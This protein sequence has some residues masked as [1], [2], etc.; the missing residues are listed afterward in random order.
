MDRWGMIIG[1]RD[2]DRSYTRRMRWQ[3]SGS[4]IL[5]SKRESREGRPGL[6]FENIGAPDQVPAGAFDAFQA[7][8]E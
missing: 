2:V 7:G 3:K 5:A 4:I 8:D 6:R 1:G